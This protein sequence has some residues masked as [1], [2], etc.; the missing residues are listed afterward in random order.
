LEED[1]LLLIVNIIEKLRRNIKADYHAFQEQLVENEACNFILELANITSQ[2]T[3]KDPNFKL[4]RKEDVTSKFFKLLIVH[5]KEQHEV[6]FYATEL[7]MTPEHLS[8][9]L[10]S[11]S[12]KTVNKWIN[13][14][15]TSESKILLRNQKINIQEVSEQLNFADQSSFGKFFKKQ[16]GYTPIEYKNSIR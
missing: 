15:L 4:G 7:C 5:C 9:I 2:R 11:V 14:A 3:E 1:Q 12:G 16:T 8:R 10:K 13:D 6:S